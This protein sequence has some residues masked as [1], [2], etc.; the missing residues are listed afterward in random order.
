[1]GTHGNAGPSDVGRHRHRFKGSGCD[2][3]SLSPVC[4]A[5][6]IAATNCVVDA[7]MDYIAEVYNGEPCWSGSHRHG[8]LER[9]IADFTLWGLV[10]RH[11]T[12]KPCAGCCEP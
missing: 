7:H 4:K 3:T 10:A 5:Q 2:G 6:K 11:L 1:M 8:L 9:A 12:A